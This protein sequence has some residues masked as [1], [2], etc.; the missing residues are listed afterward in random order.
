[1]EELDKIRR[2]VSDLRVEVGRLGRMRWITPGSVAVAL[3]AMAISGRTAPQQTPPSHAPTQLAQDLVC[4]SLKVVDA[5]G[6]E[7]IRLSSDKDGGMV[8]VDGADGKK[9]FFVA[10]ENGSGFADWYDAAGMRRAS[11]FTGEKGNVELR[12][13]DKTE[14]PMAVL[15]QAENG[16]FAVL[17]GL[18]G[19]NRLAA[20]VDNGGG[21]LDVYD[22]QAALRESFY[23]SDRNTAQ[24]KIL[25]PDK[26]VQLLLSG[27]AG[28][29]EM[30][31]YDADGKPKATWP[32]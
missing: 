22:A 29:G 26:A 12:L 13:N 14:R 18:D 10:V 24:F 19:N 32:K 9:R 15:Q 28:G 7:M 17:N 20:G 11:V 6:A 23:L 30:I 3:V 25:G 8:V 21:Y 27:A 16:G 31:S 5:S 2:E 4:K 1:M